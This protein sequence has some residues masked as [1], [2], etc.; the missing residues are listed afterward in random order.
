MLNCARN[1]WRRSDE[2]IA[3]RKL[4]Y[5]TLI[6]GWA[7]RIGQVRA[8]SMLITPH[9]MFRPAGLLQLRHVVDNSQRAWSTLSS[10]PDPSHASKLAKAGFSRLLSKCD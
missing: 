6:T 2:E 5:A 9:I 10:L 1:A 8:S 3:S 4:S 7:T